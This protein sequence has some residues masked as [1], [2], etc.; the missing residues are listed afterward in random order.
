MEKDNDILDDQLNGDDLFDLSL[1]DLSPEE[2]E[3]ENVEEEPDEDIIEL[4]DL[5][6]KGGKDLEELADENGQSG[7]TDQQADDLLSDL[8][9][10]DEGDEPLSQSDLDL[11]DT[12]L[13]EGE[14]EGV[15][16]EEEVTEEDFDQLLK[17]DSDS[18]M[19]LA[20]DEPTKQ[21]DNFDDLLND[22]DVAEEITDEEKPEDIPSDEEISEE[23]FEQLLDESPESE[24]DINV[25]SPVEAE[26]PIE[27]LMEESLSEEAPG[28]ES[29][30]EL[31]EEPVSIHDNGEE[32]EMAQTIQS[33]IEVEDDFEHLEEAV[34]SD[35]QD[36][37]VSDISG[38]TEGDQAISSESDIEKMINISEETI[39]TIVERVVGNVVERVA[40]ETMVEVAEK[41][42]SEAIDSLKKSLESDSD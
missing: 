42:I 21:E 29:V 39:E 38:E 5:V 41:L 36:E 11:T 31:E 7:G 2:K 33:P 28:L 37:T 3:K 30:T 20:F 25:D 9:E 12:S 26:E 13:E 19:G 40:R 23:D 10:G 18:D 27:D 34:T 16:I 1:D 35:I 8:K 15:Q 14:T 22:T 24:L 32:D 4:I 17:D 6:E